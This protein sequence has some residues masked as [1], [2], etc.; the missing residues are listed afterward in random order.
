[1][2]TKSYD[3]FLQE[4]LKQPDLAAEYLSVALED[5]SIDGFLLALRNVAEANGGIGDLADSA[6]LS[7]QNMYKMLSDRGNPTLSSLWKILHALGLD[8]AFRPLR[9]QCAEA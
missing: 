8:I 7:R 1:M 2:P 9:V 5:G 3:A 4:E 6:H